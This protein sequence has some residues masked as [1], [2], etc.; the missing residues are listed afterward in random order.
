MLS[1][2]NH[3]PNSRLRGRSPISNDRARISPPPSATPSSSLRQPGLLRRR[4]RAVLLL[5]LSTLLFLFLFSSSHD[6]LGLPPA[7]QGLRRVSPASIAA[8]V[9]P[10]PGVNELHGLLY[11]AVQENEALADDAPDPTRPID[12]SVY[13]DGDRTSDWSARVKRLDQTTPLIVFSKVCCH[14][15]LRGS[16]SSPDRSVLGGKKKTYCS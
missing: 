11:Y 13:A 6:L 16:L 2:N 5:T 10:R 8:L 15:S 3:H 12:L 1:G 4:R 14:V 7:L 9:R